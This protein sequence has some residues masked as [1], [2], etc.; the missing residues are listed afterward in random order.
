MKAYIYWTSDCE[1]GVTIEPKELAEIRKK[2][3]YLFECEAPEEVVKKAL[4]DSDPAL[5][6]DYIKHKWI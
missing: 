1:F 2:L 6:W 3:L 5:L 4:E